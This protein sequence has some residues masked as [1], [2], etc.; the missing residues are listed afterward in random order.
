MANGIG[1]SS[2]YMVLLVSLL[3]FFFGSSEYGLYL[4][5]VLNVM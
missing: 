4:M 5:I 3:D 1:V 2:G